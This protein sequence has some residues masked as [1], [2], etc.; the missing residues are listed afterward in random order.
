MK[1]LLL[2]LLAAVLAGVA[3]GAGAQLRAIPD[4]AKRAVMSHVEVMTVEVDG[5][6]EPLAPG[7]QIRD[8]DNRLVVPTALQPNTLVKIQ[9]DAQGAVSRVWILSPQE[10][11]QQDKQ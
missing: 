11:E 2:P 8:A 10:A 1:R 5:K 4:D 7:A 9:R 3:S 6:P